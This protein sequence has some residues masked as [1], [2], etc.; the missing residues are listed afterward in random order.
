MAWPGSWGRSIIFFLTS[1][2][3]VNGRSSSEGVPPTPTT[4]P[5]SQ[6]GGG[7]ARGAANVGRNRALCAGPVRA[8]AGA[9]A[10]E[11]RAV[12]FQQEGDMWHHVRA[13]AKRAAGAKTSSSAEAPRTDVARFETQPA[14]S[15]RRLTSGNG[16][17]R[18][19]NGGAST[20]RSAA[21]AT[22]AVASAA[23]GGAFMSAGF[24]GEQMLDP[25]K[26]DA[27]LDHALLNARHNRRAGQMYANHKRP[28]PRGEHYPQK[29]ARC[30][31]PRHQTTHNP[32]CPGA[33]FC[34]CLQPPAPARAAHA[35]A[36]GGKSR[37]HALRNGCREH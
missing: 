14:Q 17:P 3:F 37:R 35:D 21:R 9:P 2:N 6:E 26:V 19:T 24:W 8:C 33:C 27:D 20:P 15:P 12:P 28:A 30:V 23:G 29:R 36:S 32:D 13:A 22:S 10:G 4:A 16:T 34:C 18:G 11:P 1:A 5:N 25:A 7:R 31:A